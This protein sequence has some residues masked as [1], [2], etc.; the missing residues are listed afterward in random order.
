MSTGT[1]ERAQSTEPGRRNRRVLALAA[2]AVAAIA[3]LIVAALLIGGD[4]PQPQAAP[5]ELSLGEGDGLASCLAFDTAILADMSPAFEGTVTAKDG[6]RI[7]LAVD[8][9]FTGGDATEVSLIGP[10]GLEALI[11]GIDFQVGDQYLITAANGT[12][13]YCGYSGAAT[14]ELRAAFEQAFGA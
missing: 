1:I 8:R 2:V 7:T 5:L 10:H 9:W 6:E 12:V 3:A 13:N 4:D 14:P 11:G